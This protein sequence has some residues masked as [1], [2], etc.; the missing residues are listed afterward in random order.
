MDL[1]TWKARAALGQQAQPLPHLADRE[2][3]PGLG[4]ESTVK[5]HRVKPG[6]AQELSW[7][8]DGTPHSPPGPVT[9][10]SPRASYE[11]PATAKNQAHE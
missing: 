9:L 4:V 5:S 3:E 11:H 10:A 8:P 6:Y 7:A 2:N 1:G